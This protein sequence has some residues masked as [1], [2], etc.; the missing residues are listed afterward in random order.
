MVFS[1][2]GVCHKGPTISG[3]HSLT[4]STN[5]SMLSIYFNILSLLWLEISNAVDRIKF[6]FVSYG[7][8]LLPTI[9]VKD[10]LFLPLINHLL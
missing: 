4:L 8:S 5:A 3:D 1:F 10:I 2:Y 9:V 7:Y 6:S